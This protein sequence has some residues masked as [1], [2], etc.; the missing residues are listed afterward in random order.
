MKVSSLLW[1]TER[2]RGRD[3]A[4]LQASSPV[5]WA[6]LIPVHSFVSHTF[7]W[8]PLLCWTLYWGRES[9]DGGNEGLFHGALMI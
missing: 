1:I 6:L 2:V 7:V 5:P 9:T 4:R 8:G 3:K